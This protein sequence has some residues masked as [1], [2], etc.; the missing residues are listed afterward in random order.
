MPYGDLEAMRVQR[1]ASIADIDA[2]HPTIEE[3][4]EYERPA[5]MGMLVYAGVDYEEITRLA[6]DECDV[7]IWDGGNNDLPFLRPDLSIVVADPLRPGDELAYY[8]GEANLRMADLVIVNKADSATD[9]QVRRVL[10][11]IAAANPDASVMQADSPVT[12]DDGP[13]LDG[14]TALVVEDGPTITHGG[15]P[16]GAGTVAAREAGASRVDPRR[17]AVGSIRDTFTKYPHIG[18]VLP[19]MGYG[20]DQLRDLERTINDTEC[21]VVVDGHPDRPGSPDRHAPPDPPRDLRAEPPQ[22]PEPR[23]GAGAD[24]PPGWLA[25]SINSS[26]P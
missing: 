16:F 9:E 25:N 23:R 6:E 15:M 10:E 14:L 3:R 26:G 11:D 2:S 5:E 7:L 4:E 12:L 17:Y 18:P 24:H 13:P 22:R 20:D 19:A 1:F 21:D 8:P